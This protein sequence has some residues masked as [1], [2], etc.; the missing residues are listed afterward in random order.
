[1]DGG[2][3]AGSDRVRAGAGQ[4]DRCDGGVRRTR[5]R[6]SQATPC[7]NDQSSAASAASTNAT[8]I[9]CGEQLRRDDD[10]HDSRAAATTF[11]E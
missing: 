10:E 3:R 8:A 2:H 7:P 5:A 1:M 4:R 6:H 9:V 11:A